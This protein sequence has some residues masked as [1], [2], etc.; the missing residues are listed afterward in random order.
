VFTPEGTIGLP[1][2]SKALMILRIYRLFLK[3]NISFFDLKTVWIPY[4]LPAG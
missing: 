2:I 4:L 3:E 1:V